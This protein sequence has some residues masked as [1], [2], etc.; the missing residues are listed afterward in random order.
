MDQRACLWANHLLGNAPDAALLEVT[1]GGLRLRFEH[2][3]LLSL[4]GA[5]CGAEL[6]GRPLAPWRSFRVEPG[7]RLEFGYST[8]GMRSYVG[9]AGGLHSPRIFHSA[10][11]VIRE[12]LPGPLGRPLKKGDSI[13][14]EDTGTT[15]MVRRVP[16]RDAAPGPVEGVLDLPLYPGYEWDRFSVEDRR[17][18]F[19]NEWVVHPASDRVATRLAGATLKS[20][21]TV[22]DSVPLV[23]GTVQITGEGVPLVF[24]RDRPTIGGYPKVGSIDPVALDALAQARPGTAVRFVEGDRADGL[25]ALRRRADFFGWPRHE[26]CT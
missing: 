16:P 2:G 19:E 25:A 3:G 5:E 23:D 4:T 15:R 10:S 20:G 6:D 14:W 1:L 24:M 21:P 13:E 12:G 9:F 17:A 11:V 8:S 22:L 18:A 26:S 7:E